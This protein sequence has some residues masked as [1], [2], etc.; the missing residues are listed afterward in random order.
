MRA[1]LA[2]LIATFCFA[3]AA[4]A[5]SCQQWNRMDSAQ[6]GAQIERM[7]ART[8]SGSGGRKYKVDRGAI[9]RCLYGYSRRMEYDF[10]A[11][12]SD[13]RRASMRAIDVV[14]KDYIW[15]CVR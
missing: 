8:M 15:S 3:P 14:F 1:L 2:V 5:L 13:P 4:E 11:V 7:I 10:D 12:C 9:E 6:K